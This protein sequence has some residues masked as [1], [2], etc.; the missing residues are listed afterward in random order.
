[1]S[2]QPTSELG[3]AVQEVAERAQLLVHEEIELA[4][5]EMGEKVSKLI[6]GAVV[7]AVAAV[8][9]LGAL[10]FALHAAAWAIWSL[11]SDGN[12]GTIWLGFAVLAVIL[13]VVGAIASLIA[14]R[15]VKR[16]S[17][18]VPSMAIEEA[19]LIRQT[20]T[21]PHPA[22]LSD[23]QSQTSTEVGR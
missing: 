2:E 11:L 7:G 13:I 5:A 16:G 15:L 21:R 3:Q 4:K 8:F 18:P 10:V 14:F 9:L 20:V 22:T 17:P 19:Q 23:D 6:R 1:M 12:G